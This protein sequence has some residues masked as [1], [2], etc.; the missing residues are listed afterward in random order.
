MLWTDLTLARASAKPKSVHVEALEPRQLLHGLPAA[1][2]TSEPISLMAH[3]VRPAV[4]ASATRRQHRQTSINWN[5][6]AP[7]PVP[8]FESAAETVGNKVYVYGGFIDRDVHATARSAAYDMHTNT[9]TQI[10]ALPEPL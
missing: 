10:P 7:S 3:L 5:A 9:W 6:V 8:R 4:Q 2:P 1:L